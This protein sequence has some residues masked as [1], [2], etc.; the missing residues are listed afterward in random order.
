MANLNYITS[1]VQNG[2]GKSF[3]ATG[4]FPIVAKRAWQTYNDMLEYVNDI[5]DSCFAGTILAVINDS[6]EKNNG[7]YL[8]VSCPTLSNPDI[9]TEI[10]KVGEGSGSLA[11]ANFTVTGDKVKEAT[12]DN[13]GQVIYITT[14][15]TTYPSGPYIV[16]GV[17][18]VARIGTTTASGDLAGDV[19][20]LKGD[21]ATLKDTV[22]GEDSGLVKD[23]K[24]LKTSVGSITIPV[25]DVTYDNKSIIS[26][27][28]T[29]SL[30]QFAKTSDYKIKDVATNDKILS[31][32]D[33]VIGS[34]ISY[35]RESVNGVD[36]LVLKGVN[37]TVIGSI[38]VADFVAD[39]MLE[40]VEPVSDT[41]KFKFVFKK[42]DGSTAD[43][44]VDF[45]K[46]VDTYHADNETLELDSSTNTF[47]VKNNVFVYKDGNYNTLTS[48]AAKAYE[49]L[50][51]ETN[52]TGLSNTK[53]LARAAITDVTIG[54][55]QNSQNFIEIVDN[56][57]PDFGGS[58]EIFG[59]R[60]GNIITIKTSPIDN[61]TT[62]LATNTNV[63]EYL[64]ELMS[65]DEFE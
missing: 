10:I 2:Y 5:N 59:R 41:N 16:T 62:G 39:G 6:N 51:N 35:T 45:S 8:V 37:N 1:S 43:F 54:V 17:G 46:F 63:F 36:S 34:T 58:G 11:I 23:V 7:V 3:I 55:N 32:T 20:V 9:A 12:A 49:I 61:E 31:A 18:T 24:D 21:V 47:K 65:W 19:N 38:P 22:G 52:F 4:K 25:K 64:Q 48:N 28:G 40:S 14:G 27:D 44:E 13:I 30:T 42:V 33:G 50:F 56:S 53:G 29:V 60:S 26:E 57:L 15:N